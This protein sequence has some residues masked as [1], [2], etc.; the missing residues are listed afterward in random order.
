M[1]GASAHDDGVAGGELLEA[2]K[3]GGEVPDELIVV[4]D[5]AVFGGGD[6][7]G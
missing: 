1:V 3:V 6:D 4:A 7:D 5:N 2:A